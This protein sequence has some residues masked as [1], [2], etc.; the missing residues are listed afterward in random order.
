[1]DPQQFLDNIRDSFWSW[2]PWAALAAGVAFVVWLACE[3]ILPDARPKIRA[4]RPSMKR[5][6]D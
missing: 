5:V 4:Y 6:E 3:F 1:M 2:A